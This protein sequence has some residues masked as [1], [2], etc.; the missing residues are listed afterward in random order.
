M[1]TVHIDKFSN[2][3][4]LRFRDSDSDP[5]NMPNYLRKKLEYVASKNMKPRKFYFYEEHE[6]RYRILYGFMGDIIDELRD[7]RKYNIQDGIDYTIDK[8]LYKVDI[9]FTCKFEPRGEQ[10]QYIDAVV[11]GDNGKRTLIDLFTGGGKSFILAKAM[12]LLGLRP[13]FIIKATY[14][15]KWIDDF[16]GYFGISRD[17]FYVIRGQ[18]SV[19][20]LIASPNDDYKIIIASTVTMNNYIKNAT[21]GENDLTPPTE[22]MDKI[23]CSLLLSDESHQHT[24]ILTKCI[25]L[26]DPV[27]TI[28]MT[29]TL[30]SGKKPVEHFYDAMFPYKNR[31]CYSIFIPHISTVHAQYRIE[32]NNVKMSYIRSGF[33]YSQNNYEKAIMGYVSKRRKVASNN[34]DEYIG[35]INKVLVS[36]FIDRKK[37]NERCAI[38]VSTIELA[39]NLHKELSKMYP[40]LKVIRYVG[41][42]EYRPIFS[43]DIIVSNH[44]KLG[45][46]IDVKGLI[47]TIDTILVSDIAAQIQVFGRLRPHESGTRYCYLSNGY[48]DIH[49]RMRYAKQK[50]IWPRSKDVK[51]IDIK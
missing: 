1:I 25:M 33:G 23:R 10:Q 22:F 49:T 29:A 6:K 30:I 24:D 20:E 41:K 45:T 46:G 18:E 44:S 17:D 15:E 31:L 34:L 32:L 21:I 12:H 8:K 37:D 7:F 47:T 36:E 11:S 4:G 51:E 27:R 19:D 26:F 2:S 50:V 16:I 13:L 9:P 39:H 35:I 14:I 38:M 48:S 28:G 43:A 42:D 40:T 3:Y 5:I